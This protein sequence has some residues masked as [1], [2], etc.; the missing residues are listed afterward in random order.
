MASTYTKFASIWF[1]N[2]SMTCS[3]SPLRMS[4]WFT[5]THT[6]FFPMALDEQRRHHRGVHAAGQRQQHLFV[7]HLLANGSDLLVDE[8]LG[9]LGGGDAIHVV[10]ANVFVH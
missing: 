7:A 2:T 9:Q 10:G 6:R 4:P 8:R 1:W 3:D 5:C